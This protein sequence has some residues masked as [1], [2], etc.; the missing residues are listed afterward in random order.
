MIFNLN[1][2]SHLSPWLLVSK[3]N[4]WRHEKQTQ[5]LMK[6]LSLSSS[7]FFTEVKQK[8]KKQK[9]YLLFIFLPLTAVSRSEPGP[10][11]CTCVWFG[12]AWI[13]FIAFS[14]NFKPWKNLYRTFFKCEKVSDDNQGDKTS[15]CR[16]FTIC[17]VK[18]VRLGTSQKR[19]LKS[20]WPGYCKALWVMTQFCVTLALFN[21]E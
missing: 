19:A 9:K 10:Y 16:V 3:V 6:S 15:C 18:R 17:S 4:Y 2:R 14:L 5:Q 20:L 8:N 7:P 21:R 13:K 12:T 11:V 1:H